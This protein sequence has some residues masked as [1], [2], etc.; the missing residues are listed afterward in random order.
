M[1]TGDTRTGAYRDLVAGLLEVRR[2]GAT[3]RFD[4][5]VAAALAEGRL[6]E[7]T[8]R[9]LRWWQ[10]ESLRALTEHACRVIP[11]TLVT[12]TTAEE[13]A[14]DDAEEAAASWARAVGDGDQAPRTRW[15]APPAT[16]STSG[17]DLAPPAPAEPPPPAD[18]AERRG[19]RM[20]L[21][22]LTRVTTD[23]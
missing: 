16:D 22:G 14:S 17:G 23:G 3:E 7:R 13:V 1:T 5:E 18:L 10:R 19:R 9:V 4:A 12:L 11:P 21:A 6:D 15:E 2:D 8:A 20:L